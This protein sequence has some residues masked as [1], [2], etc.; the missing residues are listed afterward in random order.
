MIKCDKDL[1]DFK[2]YIDRLMQEIKADTDYTYI[3]IINEQR[4]NGAIKSIQININRV[5]KY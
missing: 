4:E 2:D 3:P 5:E 1:K